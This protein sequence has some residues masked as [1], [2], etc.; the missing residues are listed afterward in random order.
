M[1][2]ISNTI[3]GT[4]DGECAD[5]NITNL[6]GLDITREVWENVFDSEEYKQ[7]I[8]QGWYIG[9]LGHPDDPSCQDFEHACI[10]MTDGYIDDDGK[11]YGAFNLIDTPVGRVVKSF[12]D[13][14]V[15]FG[16]SVRGA[17]DI[18]NNSVD[19]D[20]FVFRGFDLVT[21]PAY[22]NS[23]PEFQEIAASTDL[24]KR[25]KYRKVCAAIKANASSLPLS[26]IDV[27]Q[28]QFAPQS[29]EF[30]L[31]ETQ[32]RDLEAADMAD[33]SEFADER[34][35]ALMQMYLDE[36]AKNEEL[37]SELNS[38]I[39]ESKKLR[40][41]SKSVIAQTKRKSNSFMQ[42]MESQHDDILDELE[43]TIQANH[44]L[45]DEIC[46]LE[47]SLSSEI[48]D[49]G[50]MKSKI[51]SLEGKLST[52]NR[53]NDKLRSQVQQ[54]DE[55]LDSEIYATKQLQDKIHN[56]ERDLAE[57]LEINA[58]ETDKIYSSIDTLKQSN[59]KYKDRI[60]EL[61]ETNLIY[62]GEVENLTSQI[63]SK[64]KIIASLRDE[65][66][67]TVGESEDAITETSNLEAQNKILAA[68]ITEANKLIAEYQQAYASL[69]AHAVGVEIDSISISANASVSDIQKSI[70]K[71]QPRSSDFEES[72]YIDTDT[73]DGIITM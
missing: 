67:D 61:K 63:K 51:K 64:D 62:K 48:R 33:N 30:E 28:P 52:K 68:D 47:A 45:E 41:K 66:T 24:G 2:K 35:D 71:F 34:L 15:Q 36:K 32:R 3:I 22:P 44:E 19:P 29:K 10:V 9:F 55:E 59:N 8:E 6:N 13:A 50:K 12:I 23:I 72:P 27:I 58:D 39:A 40:A 42:I 53:E 54:L 49:N 56:L 60:N 70:Q 26:S 11:V 57:T 73:S 21:F 37:E 46:D 1:A 20:T 7:A 18:E 65:V 31:L 14:G 43:R 16:I 69:Y 38:Q 17:G 5:A 25:A 4:F